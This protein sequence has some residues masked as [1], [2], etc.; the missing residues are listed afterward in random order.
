MEVGGEGGGVAVDV[1]LF[2]VYW[3]GWRV[4]SREGEKEMEGGLIAVY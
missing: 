1:V 4:G 2:R 3:Y